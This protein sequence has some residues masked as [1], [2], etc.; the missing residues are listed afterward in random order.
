MFV[1]GECEGVGHAVRTVHDGIRSTGYALSF[2][3]I[4]A[5]LPAH[6]PR[7]TSADFLSG[8]TSPPNLTVLTSTHALRII[9]SRVSPS[10]PLR[11]VAV[12]VEDRSCK[13]E[14]PT[15]HVLRARREIVISAGAYN[16]PVLL[17]HSGIGPR[18]H[19]GD[20][21]LDCAVDLKGTRVL[22]G[23]TVATEISL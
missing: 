16:S 9:L 7:P 4:P 15:K 20:V 3:S 1:E 5:T 12:E 2:P 6:P 13:V 10:A 19:L 21:R 23:K 8:A 17:M 14:P 18:E 11:A 22:V